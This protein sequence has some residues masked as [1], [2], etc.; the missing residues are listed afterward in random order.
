MTLI[1]EMVF[2]MLSVSRATRRG[3]SLCYLQKLRGATS[4]LTVIVCVVS[5]LITN[6]P[7]IVAFCGDNWSVGTCPDP[8]SS[9]CGGS[10][11]QTRDEGGIP[12]ESR[13]RDSD[14]HLRR[15]ELQILQQKPLPPPP[16]P[17]PPPK[18]DVQHI[19]ASVY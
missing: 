4:R 14:A 6:H 11:S 5:Q 8:T 15:V 17:P 9:P 16:P 1:I 3:K 2:S 13:L 7:R 12:A 19:V 18:Q 10:S